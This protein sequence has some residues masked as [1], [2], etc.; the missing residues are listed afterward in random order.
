MKIILLKDVKNVGKKDQIIEVSDGYA[1][2]YLIPRGLAVKMTSKEMNILKTNKKQQQL[3]EEKR[4]EEAKDIKG[5]IETLCLEFFAPSSK[6]GRMF[7]TISP[8]QIEQE[9]LNK[10][11]ITIDKRKLIDKDPINSFGYSNLRIELYKDVIA[12]IKVHVSEKK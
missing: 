2:N 8:K 9:L 11:Q 4:K 6:D 1:S 12:T 7:G 3:D 10:Y 5:R